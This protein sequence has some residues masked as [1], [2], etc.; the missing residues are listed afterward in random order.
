[1]LRPGF[2]QQGG[3]FFGQMRGWHKVIS[4]R[5]FF[6]GVGQR[7]DDEGRMHSPHRVVLQVHFYQRRI[8]HIVARSDRDQRGWQQ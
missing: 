2:H 5:E 3:G 1:M 6:S 4:V 7:A 8:Y